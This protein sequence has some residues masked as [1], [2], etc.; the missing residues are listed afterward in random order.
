MDI[1]GNKVVPAVMAEVADR[2]PPCFEFDYI[3]EGG[4][5]MRKLFEV[6]QEWVGVEDGY[7]PEDYSLWSRSDYE[8]V[9]KNGEEYW[10]GV[11][12]AFEDPSVEWVVTNDG[13]VDSVY[14][15][16]YPNLWYACAQCRPSKE[17]YHLQLQP[18]TW[19]RQCP[20]PTL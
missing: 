12:K 3:G 8:E 4:I 15:E 11:L 18:Q 1:E 5:D 2:W 20:Q 16:K 10:L 14:D 13:D 6:E 7:I 17:D 9:K 19:L